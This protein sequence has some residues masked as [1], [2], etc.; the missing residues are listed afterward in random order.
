M[1][2]LIVDSDYYGRYE[3]EYLTTVDYSKGVVE[4]GA[5]EDFY[6]ECFG[7]TT[8][9]KWEKPWPDNYP[10]KIKDAFPGQLKHLYYPTEATAPG[11]PLVDDKA[12]Q[13][14]K[15]GIK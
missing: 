7:K 13:K 9:A 8:F 12:V 1:K 6:T 15:K 2:N 14:F 4:A 10:D 3:C 5:I 11:L